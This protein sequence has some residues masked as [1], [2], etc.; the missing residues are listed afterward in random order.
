MRRETLSAFIL[1]AGALGACAENSP[2][3]TSPGDVAFAASANKD[4]AATTT[5]ADNDLAVAPALQIRSDALGSYTNSNNLSSVIQPIGAWVLDSYNPPH[6]TRRVYLEFSQPIAG[7]GP[8]GGAPVAVPSG[9]YLARLI[10]R[11]NII[12]TSFLTMAPGSSMPCPLHVAFDYSGSSYAVQMN[13]GPAG[14]DPSPETN[15]A[16][17]TCTVPSS[18][19]APC[20]GW[21]ITPSGA[22]GQNVARLIK[23]VATGRNSTTPVNQGDFYFSFS[24][25]VTAP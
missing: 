11:C 21:T 16:T 24:I 2:V 10:A 14:N 9:L 22:G 25:G 13:P 19:S 1:L 7:S 6:G 8:G 12:G 3:A 20:T 18:G 23:Y 17:I 4:V 15:Y 5:I